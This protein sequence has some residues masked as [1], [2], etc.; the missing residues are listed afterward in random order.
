MG[1]DLE[2]LRTLVAAAEAGSLSGAAR[3]R[4]LTQPAVSLQMKALEED[5]GARLFHRRGRGVE[6]TAAGTALVRHARRTLQ[7][8]RAAREEVAEIMGAGR[9]TLRLGV[10]DAAA[11][12]LLPRAFVPF[13][14]LHPGIE[15]SVEVGSTA[16]LAERLKEGE[17]DLVLGTLPVNDPDLDAE[18]LHAERLLLAAPPWARGIAVARLAAREPFIAYP[19]D[20]TT[21]R[22]V[23]K[24]VSAAG[25][26]IR[27][28]MEIGRPSVMVS[29]VEAGLGIS[30]L[31]ESLVEGLHAAGRLHR[32]HP[33]RFRV[34][35]RLGLMRLRA[36][37]PEPAARA[38]AEL[39]LRLRA[40]LAAEASRGLSSSSSS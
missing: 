14:R 30:V 9:G 36:R 18:V 8:V 22:L 19:R 38:F 29:L 1:M 40:P 24:A 25:F 6:L 31:P 7:G 32:V 16:P 26:E 17:L 27:P 20:S 10:T 15:V 2:Q 4:H 11:T 23:E 21:R 35:R 34:E 12:G 3:R 28:M 39:L 13:R 33:R 37:E 5:L